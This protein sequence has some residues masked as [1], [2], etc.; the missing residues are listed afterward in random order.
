MKEKRIFAIRLP[1]KNVRLTKADGLLLKLKIQ[2]YICEKKVFSIIYLLSNQNSFSAENC[3][4]QD[5]R[6]RV[7]K[8]FSR[9]KSIE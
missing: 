2:L 6:I 3:I 8:D 7:S 4:L 1:C 5:Y 9:R